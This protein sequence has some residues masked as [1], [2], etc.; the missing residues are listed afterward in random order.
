MIEKYILYQIALAM[1]DFLHGNDLKNKNFY[2][3]PRQQSC[4]VLIDLLDSL[5]L[6]VIKQPSPIPWSV[7]ALKIWQISNIFHWALISSYFK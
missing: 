2:W 3:F 7:V 1:A 5:I 4:S 6:L